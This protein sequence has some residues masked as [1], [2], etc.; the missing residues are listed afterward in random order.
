MHRQWIIPAIVQKKFV[1]SVLDL[2]KSLWTDSSVLKTVRLGK[3]KNFARTS[4]ALMTTAIVRILVIVGSVLQE[5]CVNNK[6]V[7]FARTPVRKDLVVV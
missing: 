1:R 3:A 5:V 2:T 7:V 6:R 4:H